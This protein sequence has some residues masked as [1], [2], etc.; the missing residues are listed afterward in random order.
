[1]P[2]GGE[3]PGSEGPGRNRLPM[4]PFGGK[5][6]NRSTGTGGLELLNCFD[7]DSLFSFTGRFRFSVL[8]LKWSFICLSLLKFTE[9]FGS[10]PA[11]PPLGGNFKRLQSHHV[12]RTCMRASSSVPSDQNVAASDPT[13]RE[14]AG[15]AGSSVGVGRRRSGVGQQASSRRSS[16]QTIRT[17]DS[18]GRSLRTSEY[19]QRRRGGE[20][21]EEA[22]ARES[23]LHCR[24]LPSS[25]LS[26]CGNFRPTGEERRRER[27]RTAKKPEKRSTGRKLPPRHASSCCGFRLN[28]RITNIWIE[29]DALHMILCLKDRIEKVCSPNLFYLI[30]EIKQ[31]LSSFHVKISHIHGEGNSCADWFA[32]MGSNLKCPTN[33]TYADL[34]SFIKGLIRLDKMGLPYVR[35]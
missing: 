10:L 14:V 31:M 20:S 30:R 4:M 22:H 16:D 15:G 25:L 13:G 7:I 23:Y 28:C 26:R 2:F 3:S 1:M 35:N 12:T 32:N 6:V 34:P 24:K 18:T 5:T 29:G 8:P 9:N 27:S 19:E 17:S 33:F 21:T 11:S